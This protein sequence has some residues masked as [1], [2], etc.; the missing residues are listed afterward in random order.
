MIE[1]NDSNQDHHNEMIESVSKYFGSVKKTISEIV[2]GSSVAVNI[3]IIPPSMNQNFVTLV[4]TG[5]SDE[6]MDYSNE[7]GNFQYAELIIKLPASWKVEEDVRD[8]AYY[9]PISWLEKAAHI[10]HIYN[11]WLDEG[12]I[13][14]NGEPPH[15]F[16][17]NT[18]LSCIMIC[19]PQ[20][21]GLD[22][23]Q[24]KHG[25]IKVFSLIPIYEE[26]R[27]LALEKGYEYLLKKMSEKGISD[28]L[29]IHRENV[30]V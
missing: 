6:P 7:E 30:G 1:S 27:N 20:E 28:V 24:T 17:T 2:P 14:P 11:G 26:E 8:I 13:I 21:D 25:D 4:T 29:D 10:P 9:W 19:R 23:V 5:M 22:K 15:S 3:H 12:V 18:K 16:A